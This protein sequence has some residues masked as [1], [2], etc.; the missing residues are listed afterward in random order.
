MQVH[1]AFRFRLRLEAHQETLAMR[2]AG[3]R[4][5]IY[6][7]CLEQ[8]SIWGRSHRISC[9][10]QINQLPELKEHLTFLKEVPSHC[11]QSR[12]LPAGT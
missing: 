6:N 9:T 12:S 3:C 11:L 1:K 2:T 7:L 4:R 10:D 5:L 8:R